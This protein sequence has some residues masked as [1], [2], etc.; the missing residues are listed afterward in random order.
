VTPEQEQKYLLYYEQELRYLHEMGADFAA[1]HPKQ[2]RYLALEANRCEDPHVERL[3]EAFA[4][5]AARIHMKLDDDLPLV[6]EAILNAVYPQLLRPVPSMSIVEIHPTT[7]AGRMTGPFPIR[8][9]TLL[10]SAPVN[11][12]PCAFRTA[13]DLE[14][15]P[16][17]VTSAEWTSADKLESGPRFSNAIHAIRIVIRAFNGLSLGRLPLDRLR[18]HLHG[19]D[20]LTYTLYETLFTRLTSIVIRKPDS[21]LPPV[22]LPSSCLEAVGFER[23]PTRSKSTNG[24]PEHPSVPAGSDFDLLGEPWLFPYE[25][26]PLSAYRLLHEFFAFPQKFLFVDL[27][28]LEQAAGLSLEDRV[29]L[30]FLFSQVA[31]E[32]RRKRLAGIR[33]WTFKLGC[34][35]VVNLFESTFDPFTLDHRKPAYPLRFARHPEA[36]DLFAI[37]KVLG[38]DRGSTTVREYQP[39]Y[40]V[41]RNFDS[42]VP[43]I[44]WV[45]NRRPP[46]ST[47]ERG[48]ATHL[49]FVD[50]SLRPLSP[51]VEFITVKIFATN[52]DLPRALD[53]GGEMETDIGSPVS[54]VVL[55]SKP[56]NPYRPPF[57]LPDQW[58]LVSQLSLNYLSLVQEGKTALQ[59]LL[60]LY[61]FS[62]LPQNERMIQGIKRLSSER[63]FA[64]ITTANGIAF[65]RGWNIDLEMDEDHFPGEITYLFAAV[66]ERFFA[67]YATL[68]SYT[69]L[70]VR[71][72]QRKEV[73]HQW[74]PRAGERILM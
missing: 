37:R 29:E 35:P 1:R 47:A 9:G 60:R 66:L 65:G 3:L 17:S 33:S 38:E 73:V 58:R 72:T 44:F 40:S 2:A 5:L 11:G 7:E 24:T 8:S 42:S 31:G 26:R 70:T 20:A 51:P 57:G 6:G 69:Q 74:L 45:A 4:F 19:D 61:N 52:R 50:L 54:S 21:R 36:H 28:G 23:K 43:D 22:E 10:R 34:T 56:T 18:V 71:S 67:S 55:L 16:L 48:V 12:V 14:L 62:D 53:K 27:T 25:E 39:F 46:V 13:Y 32:E 41:R 30:I 64:K 68:N 63:G 59:Q 15:W 49:S